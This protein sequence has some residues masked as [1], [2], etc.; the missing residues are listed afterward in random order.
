MRTLLV[1]E[2]DGATRSLLEAGLKRIPQTRIA[3]AANGL[4]ALEVL[5]REPVDLLIT[6]L[7]MPLMDGFGLI[8]ITT[9]CYP[10]IPILVITS[11]EEVEHQNLPTTLG[12]LKIFPKPLRLSQLRESAEA[13]LAHHPAQGMARGLSLGGILQLM[14]WE[15]RD[16][17]LTVRLGPLEGQLY[18]QSGQVIHARFQDLEGLAAA[19]AI[20]AWED[21]SIVFVTEC[22]Q[23][24]SIFTPLTELLLMAAIQLDEGQAHP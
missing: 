11:L 1:A 4:E 21:P 17:T 18:L 24:R 16:A 12:A 2:D 13:L 14:E 22:E 9:Q 23:E 6:D 20:M 7:R 3:L 5:K 19:R 10:R 15:R 8:A